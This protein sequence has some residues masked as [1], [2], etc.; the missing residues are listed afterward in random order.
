M[1]IDKQLQ[2]QIGADVEPLCQ[3]FGNFLA[4]RTLAVQDVRDSSLWRTIA[5]V[6]MIETVLVHEKP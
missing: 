1:I 5:H 6:F 3:A 4:D 2:E